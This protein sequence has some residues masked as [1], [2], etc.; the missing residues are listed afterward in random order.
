MASLT[1]L[2]KPGEGGRCLYRLRK[3]LAF[4]L[5]DC[6]TLFLAHGE[7]AGV[8]AI[9]DGTQKMVAVADDYCVALHWRIGGDWRQHGYWS[10]RVYLVLT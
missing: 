9:Y 4:Y 7:L 5:S 10:F 2:Q 3:N 8:V 1:I 6:K